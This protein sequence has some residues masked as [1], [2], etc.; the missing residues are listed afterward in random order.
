[1]IEKEARIRASDM[2]YEFISALNH[3][4]HTPLNSVLGFAQLLETDKALMASDF[5]KDA[6]QQIVDAGQNLMNVV[7]AILTF[8]ELESGKVKL[9]ISPFAPLDTYEAMLESAQRAAELR[10]I[11]ID[12]LGI[13][14]AAAHLIMVD[15]I[16][17]KQ[18][19]DNVL[20]F[21]ICASLDSSTVTI[22]NASLDGMLRFTV[23]FHG[24]YADIPNAAVPFS[25]TSTSGETELNSTCSGLELAIATKLVKL[26][27]GQVELERKQG[28]LLNLWF[29]LPIVK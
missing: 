18:V 20:H 5:G 7:D 23:A 8:A 1:L 29:A 3:K 13:D 6:V 11:T 21:A 12:D 27:G 22:T 4:L 14:G 10:N 2:N 16:R 15:G 19:M 28:T 24:Q 17:F 9:S 25:P 26:M